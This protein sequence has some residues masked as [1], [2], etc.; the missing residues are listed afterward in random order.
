MDATLKKK[1]LRIFLYFPNLM[2]DWNYFVLAF[3]W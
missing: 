3:E 2:K 1:S